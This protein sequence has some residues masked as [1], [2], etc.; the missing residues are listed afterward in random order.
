MILYCFFRGLF[1]IHNTSTKIIITKKLCQINGE[2][3][4]LPA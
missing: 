3:D 1:F 4:I 2:S